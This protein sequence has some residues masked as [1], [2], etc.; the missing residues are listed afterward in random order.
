[1]RSTQRPTVLEAVLKHDRALLYSGLA[2][3][4]GLA[5][6]YTTYLAQVM[7]CTAMA[8]PQSQPWTLTD[9]WLTCVMWVVMMVAMMLPSAAPMLLMYATMQR[10]HQEQDAPFVPTSVFLLGYV[11]VWSGY[12]LAATGVQWGLHSAALLSSSMGRTGPV[13]GGVLLLGA[14]IFQWTPWKTA[15][16]A[17]CRSPLSF[18]MTHWQEGTSGALRMGLWHGIYC[19]GCCWMLMALLFAAGVMNLLWVAVLAGFVFLEKV[20]PWGDRVSQ[21]SG[22]VLVLGGALLL[23][24]G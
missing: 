13:L 3:L 6:L 18:F 7:D 10:R 5:W 23:A 24:L 20:L 12:S 8:M 14:G 17:H 2:G 22:G 21:V 4:T 11:L 15:C 16:L 19:L 1:M 9:L